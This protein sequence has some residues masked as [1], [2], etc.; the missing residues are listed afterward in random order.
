MKCEKKNI[1][2]ILLLMILSLTSLGVET[3]EGGTQGKK[4]ITIGTAPI[5]GLFYPIGLS[6]SRFI[7]EAGYNCS[8]RSTGGSGDNIDLILDDKVE[9]AIAMSDSVVQAYKGTGAYENREAAKGLRCIMGL[10]YNYVQI[11]TRKN[12]NIKKFEDLKGKKVGLGVYNSGVELNA[13]LIYEVH[14]M[15]YSD[16]EVTYA[17]PGELVEQ[18][19]KGVLDA[20]FLTNGI[21]NP[22][23]TNLQKEIDI[24]FVSMSNDKIKKLVDSHAFFH[25]EII[26]KKIYNLKKDVYTVGVKDIVICDARLSD[27][28]V[29]DITKSIIENLDELKNEHEVIRRNVF[30]ENSLENIKIPFHNGA[31]KYYKEKGILK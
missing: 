22:V 23:I 4:F 3:R 19:K 25:K 14:N 13:R 17:S 1:L 24:G 29:Y 30:L 16:T 2:L 28:V 10:H 9:I 27:K 26:N 15:N 5:S 18:L 20:I 6:F 8:V 31:I 12:S 7:K 21:P 11:I